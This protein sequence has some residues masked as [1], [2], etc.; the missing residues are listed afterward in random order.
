MVTILWYASGRQ[1]GMTPNTLSDLFYS[2]GDD[3]W[4]FV[5]IFHGFLQNYGLRGPFQPKPVYDS[6]WF[7]KETALECAKVQAWGEGC[8]PGAALTCRDAIR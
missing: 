7:D 1:V 8:A 6:L 5:F 4:C 2:D 3:V